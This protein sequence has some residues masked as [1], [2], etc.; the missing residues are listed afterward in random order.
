MVYPTQ[1]VQFYANVTLFMGVG[2]VLFHLYLDLP[3]T[4]FTYIAIG[5]N[6]VSYVATQRMIHT[7]QRAIRRSIP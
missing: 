7:A 2:L 3:F 5:I 6:V 4:I 1:R